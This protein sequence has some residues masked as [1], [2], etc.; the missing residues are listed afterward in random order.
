MSAA[1]PVTGVVLAGG[2]GTR[3]APL[4]ARTSKQLLPVAGRPLVARVI[5]QLVRAG[6]RDVLL[7]IDE[8]HASGFLDAL[9]DGRELGL[10]SLAYVWQPSSAGGMPSAIAR[11]EHHVR[12][13]GLL[14]ACGDV[15]IEGALRPAV[16]AFASRP[17][18]ARIVA[19]RVPDTA[20]QTSL[21]VRG[22]RVVALGDKDPDRHEPGLIDLGCYL[23]HRDVFD[24][25]R[26][27]RPSARGETEIWDL[28]RRYA[29]RGELAVTE[30]AGW[31]SDVGG[32]LD[33]YRAAD[34]R[35]AATGTPEPDPSIL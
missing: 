23:Y 8:R 20:A 32:G 5:D 34:A 12:T 35:Y 33:A 31:W 18:G 28:N 11:V 3:L 6:V 29:R 22:D 1:S 2:R 27:L 4:T 21:T 16:T 10:R 25:I 13:D 26:T 14:V 30:V 24:E 9:R 17:D 7:V 15:L 19:A